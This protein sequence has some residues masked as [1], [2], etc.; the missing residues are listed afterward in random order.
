MA[1]ALVSTLWLR[2]CELTY[3]DLMADE[4][5]V[6]SELRFLGVADVSNDDVSAT[7]VKLAPPLHVDS[8]S[9][10]EEVTAALSGSTFARLLRS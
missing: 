7:L 6:H 9:N 3:E 5:R 8:I 1:R 2:A 4:S 10:F